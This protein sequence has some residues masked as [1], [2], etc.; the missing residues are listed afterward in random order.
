MDATGAQEMLMPFV[1]SADVW[2]RTGRYDAIDETLVR[3]ED[4]KGHAL[5][6][7]MTH[8]E[9]VAQLAA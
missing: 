6:L 8:E 4:R 2:R 1:H 7:G 3:L 5:V 9:I